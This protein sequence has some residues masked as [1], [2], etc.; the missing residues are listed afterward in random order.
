MKSGHGNIAKIYMY[1]LKY[2]IIEYQSWNN[3][4]NWREKLLTGINEVAGE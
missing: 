1:P 2:D 3:N 4:N